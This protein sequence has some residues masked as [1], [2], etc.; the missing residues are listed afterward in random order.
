MDRDDISKIMKKHRENQ[1]KGSQNKN[2]LVE[3]LF[4]LTI[5]AVSLV[6]VP[7]YKNPVQ[8]A[9]KALFDNLHQYEK[10]Q[11]ETSHIGQMVHT[12]YEQGL[13]NYL[14]SEPVQSLSEAEYNSLIRELY[15]SLPHLK[16]EE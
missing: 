7:L 12:L 5:I 1:E 11:Q 9:G 4:P 3:K 14:D 8:N 2:S 10:T 6:A 13:A 16:N 15:F